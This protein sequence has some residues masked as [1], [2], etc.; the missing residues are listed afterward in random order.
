MRQIVGYDYIEVR[1]MHGIK[2]PVI[3][4]LEFVLI[5]EALYPG[6]PVSWIVYPGWWCPIYFI[7]ENI[8]R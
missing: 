5:I 1:W 6:C 8:V 4:G 7:P 3:N 2:P